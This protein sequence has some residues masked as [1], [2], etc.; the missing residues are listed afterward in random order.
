MQS[1]QLLRRSSKFGKIKR[2]FPRILSVSASITLRFAPYQRSQVD[3]IDNEQA[4][5]RNP[6]AADPRQQEVS[7]RTWRHNIIDLLY[8]PVAPFGS[9]GLGVTVWGVPL[10]S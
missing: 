9:A 10:P 4:G 2:L 6:R 8:R 1:V 3:L 5:A 7:G